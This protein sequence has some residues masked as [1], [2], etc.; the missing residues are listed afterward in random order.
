MWRKLQT[1]S[2]PFFQNLNWMQDGRELWLA[3]K[4]LEPCVLTG[5]PRGS[6]AE[7][8]KRAWCEQHLGKAVTVHCCK[9]KEKKNY[10]MSCIQFERR[11]AV[12]IDDSPSNCSDWRSVGGTA[13][14]HK[15]LSETLQRLRDIGLLG[16]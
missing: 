8:Q 1:A 10:A 5:L 13:V 14:E 9:S 7:P 6:W 16:V 12:L 3:V 15:S 11:T 4:E 2:T